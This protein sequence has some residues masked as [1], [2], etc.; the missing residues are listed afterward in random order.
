MQ[1]HWLDWGPPAYIPIAG[2][3]GLGK[4]SKKKKRKLPNGAEHLEVLEKEGKGDL[5][6]LLKI[7]KGGIIS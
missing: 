1:A 6:D 2:Y 7:F 3:F 4:T 5:R